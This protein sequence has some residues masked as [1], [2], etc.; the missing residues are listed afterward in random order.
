MGKTGWGGWPTSESV[1]TRDNFYIFGKG[2]Y[3][4]GCPIMD[5]M[6]A[7]GMYEKLGG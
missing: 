3:K 1:D 7:F 6:P 5:E 2:Q 4:V